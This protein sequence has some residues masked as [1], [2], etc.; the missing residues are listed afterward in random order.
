VDEVDA[1]CC[2]SD[3]SEESLLLCFY[4]RRRDSSLRLP[5]G[6]LRMTI[7]FDRQQSNGPRALPSATSGGEIG[8]SGGGNFPNHFIFVRRAAIPGCVRAKELS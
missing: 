1:F 6:G 7:L 3:R 8:Y 2:H 4:D 5:A